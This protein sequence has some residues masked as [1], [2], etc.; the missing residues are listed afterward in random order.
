MVVS[1]EKM[2]IFQTKIRFL[3]HN[4]YQRTITPNSRSIEFTNKFPNE[5]KEKTQLQRF[6]GCLNYISNFFPT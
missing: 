4:I 6:L 1:A 5:I 3:G 2:Q